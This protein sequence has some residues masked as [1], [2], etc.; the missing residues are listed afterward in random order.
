MQRA[1]PLHLG[2]V[3][4]HV[5]VHPEQ[6]HLLSLPDADAELGVARQSRNRYV[7]LEGLRK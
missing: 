5:G 7:E 4:E 2:F 1:R 3:V 6:G